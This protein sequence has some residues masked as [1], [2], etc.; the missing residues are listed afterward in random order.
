MSRLSLNGRDDVAFHDVRVV[1]VELER[2]IVGAS[3]FDDLD[4]LLRGLK[5]ESRNIAR[6]ERLDEQR[7]AVS[8]Q[9]TCGK[10]Q[11]LDERVMQRVA[12]R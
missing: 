7:D 3:L 11:I 8:L 6:V 12:I 2:Q 9:C 4:G 1:D 5:K 10:P